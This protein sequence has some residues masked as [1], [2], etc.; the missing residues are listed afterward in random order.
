MSW[1]T[2]Y[3]RHCD[4]Q[5]RRQNCSKNFFGIGIKAKEGKKWMMEFSGLA[6]QEIEMIKNLSRAGAA[7][8]I[9]GM[10]KSQEI[11]SFSTFVW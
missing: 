11:L 2:L 9:F 4:R 7:V 1:L 5:I 6:R 10:G 8:V 3:E